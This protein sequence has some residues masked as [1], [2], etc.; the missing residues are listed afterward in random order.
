MRTIAI[1]VMILAA[2]FWTP[3]WCFCSKAID[4]GCTRNIQPQDCCTN[5]AGQSAPIPGKPTDHRCQCPQHLMTYITGA[6][7]VAIA[8]TE[9]YALA[10][11]LYAVSLVWIDLHL[12]AEPSSLAPPGFMAPANARSS[13][14]LDRSCMFLI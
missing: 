2:L 10:N 12:Y 13:T 8:P 11:P 14:L 9:M 6:D 7:E 5:E 1:Y 4:A 3:V